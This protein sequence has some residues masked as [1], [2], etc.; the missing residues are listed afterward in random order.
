M[1]GAEFVNDSDQELGVEILHLVI[2]KEEVLA[3]L[4]KLSVESIRDSNG[5]GKT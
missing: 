3:R 5:F 1:F 2:S 4:R